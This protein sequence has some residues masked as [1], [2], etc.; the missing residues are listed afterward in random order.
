MFFWFFFYVFWCFVLFLL[1]LFDNVSV[2]SSTKQEEGKRE[3]ERE[4]RMV[5]FLFSSSKEQKAMRKRQKERGNKNNKEKGE[6][7]RK[8]KTQENIR[9]KR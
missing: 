6:Y 5:S 2:C 4:E 3:S 9:E 1:K 7:N 8:S